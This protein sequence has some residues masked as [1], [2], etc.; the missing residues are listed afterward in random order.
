MR[1]YRFLRAAKIAAIALV[2]V[3]V[4]SFVVMSL[5]NALLPTIFA[6]RPIDFWQAAGL[7]ILSKLLF[8]GFRT[9][10]GG[11]PRWR[12]RMMERWE[13][14]TPEERERFKQGMRRGCGPGPD[15]SAPNREAEVRA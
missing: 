12:R 11:G 3:G 15:M 2:A 10:G 5:W 7:L 6:V 8:G 9:Y 13:Q 1:K 4:V 14:M